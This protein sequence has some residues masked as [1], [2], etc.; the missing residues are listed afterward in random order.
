MV[1]SLIEGMSI[2]WLIVIFV[3]NCFNLLEKV[4]SSKFKK[5]MFWL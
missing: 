4:D 1:S 5:S 3:K 2:G